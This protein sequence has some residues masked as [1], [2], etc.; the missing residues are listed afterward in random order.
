M[1]NLTKSYQGENNSFEKFLKW[2]DE[3]E[4][5]GQEIDK[6]IKGGYNSLLE[7]GAGNGDLTEKFI[8]KFSSAT[9]VEPSESLSK[10][11]QERFPNAH[12]I[13]DKIENLN[14]EEKL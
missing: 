12:L 13:N 7:V 14:L 2:T 8:Q 9:L 5:L 11:L 6:L 3:K 10:R 1:A 4:I